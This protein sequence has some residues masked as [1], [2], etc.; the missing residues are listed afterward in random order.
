LPE[1]EELDKFNSELSNPYYPM[2][3][4]DFSFTGK[5]RSN[6]LGLNT[7]VSHFNANVQYLGLVLFAVKLIGGET[8]QM[9]LLFICSMNVNT[10]LVSAV[11]LKINI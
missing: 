10:L 7:R 8:I 4:L 9:K 6:V 5:F 2:K 11:N 3:I 1:E